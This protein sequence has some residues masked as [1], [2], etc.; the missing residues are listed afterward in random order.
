MKYAIINSVYGYGSTGS[1]AKGLFEYLNENDT[2]IAFY[3]RGKK[4]KDEKLI[5]I[6]SKFSLYFH[7][8]M[9]RLTGLEGYFSRRATAKLLRILDEFKPD[10]VILLNIHGYYLHEKKLLDY[11][12]EKQIRV[13]YIMP[14]EYPFLGACCYSNECNE[15]ER[16][17]EKCGR[18]HYYPRSLF[19]KQGRKKFKDKQK[20]YSGFNNIVFVAPE[21]NLSKARRSALLKDK[22]MFQADWGIDLRNTFYPRDTAEC[23]IKHGIPL[24]KK[25]ILSV[26]PFTDE[27]KGIKKYF[28]KCAQLSSDDKLL[29]V[30]VGYNGKEKQLPSNFLPIPYVSD[31]NSLAE[32]YC[33]ADVFVI[34]STADTMPLA[35]LMALACGVKVVSF[36]IS[37]LPL[38]YEKFGK[39]VEVGNVEELLRVLIDFEYKTKESVNETRMFAEKRYDEVEFNKTIK[40]LADS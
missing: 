2:A 22:V 32:L 3:G 13:V 17:C 6:E 37:G 7:A 8:L 1:M 40:K 12:R 20:T 29:F 16:E 27:R 9:T 4:Y 36:D 38:I 19:F 34:T 28:Y 15:F 25:V 21:F 10:A 5:K 35:C 39:A 24:D 11:L 23:R 18:R 30:N 14:D 31:Q 33:C 26:A